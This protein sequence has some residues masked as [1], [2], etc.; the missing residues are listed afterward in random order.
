MGLPSSL[1]LFLSSNKARETSTLFFIWKL[2][3]AGTRKSVALNSEDSRPVLT[4]PRRLRQ[5]GQ[6][7]QASLGY[8]VSS[9]VLCTI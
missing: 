1:Y 8:T 9:R 4:V 5:A 6:Q 2:G 3:S 7:V